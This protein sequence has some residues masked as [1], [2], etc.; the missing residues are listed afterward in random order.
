MVDNQ[1]LL[2]SCV[3]I[4]ILSFLSSDR[5]HGRRDLSNRSGDLVKILQLVAPDHCNVRHDLRHD[6]SCN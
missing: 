5:V 1:Y 4:G 3:G 2:V 6:S